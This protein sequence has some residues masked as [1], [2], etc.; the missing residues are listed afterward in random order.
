[1]GGVGGDD[2]GDDGQFVA[3]VWAFGDTVGGRNGVGYV[4]AGANDVG[5]VVGVVGSGCGGCGRASLRRGSAMSR[6]SGAYSSANR[7]ATASL[8]P[9]F[10][11]AVAVL[12]AR[13]SAKAGARRVVILSAP[14]GTV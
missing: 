5:N 7:S 9:L 14:A 13:A 2:D 8:R 12:S 11:P 6:R 3:A 4:A 10:R 1:V